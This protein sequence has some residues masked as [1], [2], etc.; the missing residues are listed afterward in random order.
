MTHSHSQLDDS[1]RVIISKSK[2]AEDFLRIIRCAPLEQRTLEVE[3]ALQDANLFFEL[4]KNSAAHY[5]KVHQDHT[6]SNEPEIVCHPAYWFSLILAELTPEELK[7]YNSKLKILFK[8]N[9]EH[10]KYCLLNEKEHDHH[11]YARQIPY[12]LFSKFFNEGCANKDNLLFTPDIVS[13]MASQAPLADL[14]QDRLRFRQFCSNNKDTPALHRLAFIKMHQDRHPMAKLK[15]C[16][17]LAIVFSHP[18]LSVEELKRLSSKLQ[19]SD[20]ILLTII[21]SDKYC[22]IGE[23]IA[24]DN[25]SLL[26]YLKPYITQA[27]WSRMI[28]ESVTWVT[29]GYYFFQRA[30]KNGQLKIL[31][32]LAVQVPG[33]LLRM[34]R[35]NHYGAFREAAKQG[36]LHVLQYLATFIAPGEL[37]KMIR[38]DN[39]YVFGLAANN[40]KLDVL[41]YFASQAPGE[42]PNMISADNYG[43]F[44]GIVY[45]YFNN[46]SVSQY[47][48][49]LTTPDEFHKMIQ[50]NQ[51]QAFECAAQDGRLD[52]LQCFAKQAPHKL[53]DM[54][55]GSEYQAFWK[56]AQ[57]GHLHVLKYL[58]T[59][60]EPSELKAM[61]QAY[62]HAAF[63][64]AARN[65]HLH[66]LKYLET[67][68][69][70]HELRS[71]IKKNNYSAFQW[72][73]KS[74]DLHIL[75]Y[76]ENCLDKYPAELKAMLLSNDNTIFEKANELDYSTVT[77]HLLSFPDM[78]EW[79]A[80]TVI[81]ANFNH[82]YMSHL[83][84]F[85]QE[86]VMNLLNLE[87]TF[88]ISHKEAE[89]LMRILDYLI[90]R[91][92][93]E[94]NEWITLLL[95]L[96]NVKA[97]VKPN[98]A[99]ISHYIDT[100]RKASNS[101][102]M[103]AL[104][105]LT[106]LRLH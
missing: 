44:K 99:L 49:T 14:S 23:S 29:G 65:G 82:S 101:K 3:A 6:P 9:N 54:I 89:L 42:L 40:E 73:A 31:Q 16:L 94:S 104:Q 50:A 26:E 51:Y 36:H 27:E 45:N 75:T 69:S 41:Q 78:F 84:N 52:V 32:Y 68:V 24:R 106:T 88:Q 47:L 30:A 61:I 86:K 91:N 57:N 17:W 20:D 33:E 105:Q 80:N 62:E 4:A 22:L 56:A 37:I 43:A 1:M 60:V 11:P 8:K 48:A 93:T 55:R 10:N 76:L 34:I 58:E 95:S 81:E 53:L 18:T 19:L 97:L 66:V 102:A 63:H 15:A 21:R 96:E 77:H 98:N 59:F 71:I 85:V 46:Y 83:D 87:Y 64:W 92:K 70:S 38:A 28:S 7:G 103:E 25:P 74:H 13:L 35:A 39:Y 90:Q 67:Y 5:Q 2:L 72:A 12:N 100:A 79:I